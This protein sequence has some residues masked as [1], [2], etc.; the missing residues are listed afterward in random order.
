MRFPRSIV[1]YF[2][3]TKTE[4]R[5]VFFILGALLIGGAIKLYKFYFQYDEPPD[6]LFDYTESDREFQQRSSEIRSGK[7][8]EQLNGGPGAEER[9]FPTSKQGEKSAGPVVGR[10]NINTASKDQLRNLPGIGAT[11]AERIVLYREEH[12]PFS[13]AYDL[14]NVRGIGDKKFEQLKRYISLE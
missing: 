7:R 2:G 5:V 6:A 13:S 3:F 9:D 14:K 1:D 8:S 11:L 12:G 10:I 4:T